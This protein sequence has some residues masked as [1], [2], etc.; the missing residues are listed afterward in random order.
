VVGGVVVVV[1]IPI[2]MM[3]IDDVGTLRAGLDRH[4][5]VHPCLFISLY[6]FVSVFLLSR[7]VMVWER[8]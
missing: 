2:T 4:Q 5:L 1:G 3:L 8:K 7:L 6:F